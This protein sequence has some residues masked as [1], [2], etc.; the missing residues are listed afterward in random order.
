M[1]NSTPVGVECNSE[2]IAN[3]DAWM[4]SFGKDMLPVLR[5]SCQSYVFTTQQAADLISKM[6][7]ESDK[8]VALEMFEQRLTNPSEIQPIV[9][10]MKSNMSM[11]QDEFT[12]KAKTVMAR[13]SWLKKAEIR[14]MAVYNKEDHGDRDDDK[15]TAF[16]KNIKDAFMGDGRR[17]VVEEE[18]KN[19]P[20]PPFSATQIK[21]VMDKF[22]W[23]SEV[24]PVLEEMINYGAIYQLTCNEIVD[25]ILGKNQH[26]RNWQ[27]REKLLV[28]AAV[29]KLI[30]DPQNKA[31][32]VSVFIFANDKAEAEEILR[33]VAVDFTPPV[34]PEEA[35]Q[36]AIRKIGGCVNGFPWLKVKGGYRCAGGAHFVND[37]AIKNQ[38]EQGNA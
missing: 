27:S 9:D 28:L 29:K 14:T 26:E 6:K 12:K 10:A 15:V 3:L 5:C 20:T 36:A 1:E 32:L 37:A 18:M 21:K 31:Y 2:C 22:T 35:I 24:V 34:P 16:A 11:N 4:T 30:K 25:N 38:M 33:D 17:K 13:E 7:W 23:G 8:M 19:R